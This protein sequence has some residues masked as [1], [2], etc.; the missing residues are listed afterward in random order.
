MLGE[1]L[2][3]TKWEQDFLHTRTGKTSLRGKR[4]LQGEDNGTVVKKLAWEGDGQAESSRSIKMRV[5]L[6]VNAI[7]KYFIPSGKAGI[8]HSWM[9]YSFIQGAVS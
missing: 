3:G 6:I 8:I 7:S 4:S 5:Q 1:R 9:P 2:T